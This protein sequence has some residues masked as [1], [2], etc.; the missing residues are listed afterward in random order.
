MASPVVPFAPISESGF[1]WLLNPGSDSF[2][3]DRL[4]NRIR[5]LVNQ[6]IVTLLPHPLTWQQ[7][8]PGV[9]GEHDSRPPEHHAE[10]DSA[11]NGSTTM[12]SGGVHRPEDEG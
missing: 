3:C 9:H 10:C 8:E 6:T 5:H 11:H 4:F 7:N 12:S 2:P 1:H